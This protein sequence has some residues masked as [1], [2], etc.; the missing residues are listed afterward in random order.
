M[1][2]RLK[3]QLLQPVEVLITPQTILRFKTALPI[4]GEAPPQMQYLTV[5][6]E[7]TRM[8]E[9]ESQE[10]FRPFEPQ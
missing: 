1:L 9:Q 5:L 10:Q 4:G 3:W 2:K 7:L 8:N 6:F